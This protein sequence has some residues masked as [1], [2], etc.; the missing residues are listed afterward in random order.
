MTFEEDNEVE[1]T[2]PINQTFLAPIGTETEK[3]CYY[4]I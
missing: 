3:K 2:W 4:R 1:K